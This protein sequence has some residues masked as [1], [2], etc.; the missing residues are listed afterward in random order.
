MD[1]EKLLEITEAAFLDELG[2]IKEAGVGSFLTGGIKTLGRL[3]GKG[4]SKISLKGLKRHAGMAYRKAGGGWEGAKAVMK[5]PAG[6]A[7]TVA[8]L[9]GLAGYGAYKGT[10]GRDRRPRGY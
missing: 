9:G 6:Q 1:D 4:G 3:G 10:I 7:A 5:S 2:Q 8:G